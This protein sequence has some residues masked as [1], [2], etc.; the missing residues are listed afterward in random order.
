MSSA[1]VILSSLSTLALCTSVLVATLS[2]RQQL[3]LTRQGRAV[4]TFNQCLSAFDD[5]VRER[6]AVETC[7]DN[8]AT[9]HLR[10]RHYYGRYW[11]LLVREFELTRAG[12]LPE[13]LFERW[14]MA[15]HADLVRPET[16]TILADVSARQ[17]WLSV[18]RDRARLI[19]DGFDALVESTMHEVDNATALASLRATLKSSKGGGVFRALA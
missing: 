7:A 15:A 3:R 16:E 6:A 18:G 12:L 17:G 8:D 19:S 1:P 5:L 10:A 9:R 11:D 4:D 14:F 13:E 2:V